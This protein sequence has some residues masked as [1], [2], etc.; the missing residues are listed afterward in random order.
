MVAIK[1]NK[2]G[3]ISLIYF[4]VIVSILFLGSCGG[5]GNAGDGLVNDDNGSARQYTVGGTVS[6]LSGTVVLQNNGGN[7]LTVS[8]N[9][10]FTFLKTVE[11][12]SSYSV[13]VL[14]QPVEQTCSVS[15]GTGTLSGA[16]IS[17]VVVTCSATAYYVGGTLSGLSGTVVLQNNGG[18]N[19]IITA[20]GPFTFPLA[21]ADGSPFA[22]TVLTQPAGQACSVANGTGSLAH[23]DVTNVAVICSTITRT[24][25]IAKGGTGTGTLSSAPAGIDCGPVCSASY[26]LGTR[27]TL[28]AVPSS[29]TIFEGFSGGCTGITSSCTLTLTGDTAVSAILNSASLSKAGNQIGLDGGSAVVV[30]QK[31]ANPPTSTLD[32]TTF[33][34]EAWVFPLADQDMLIVADSAYYLMVKAPTATQPLG[35]EFAVLTS[36]GFPAFKFFA[37]SIRPFKLAQWNHVVGMVDNINKYLWLGIN[38]ELTGPLSIAGNVDTSY[39]QTFSVGNAYPSSLGNYPFIGRIDEIRLSSAIR[40]NVDFTP[41]S[42]LD[43]DGSTAGLW[44]FDETA[45]AASFI[46][47]SG[48]SNMLIGLNGAAAIAG[49]RDV[50]AGGNSLFYSLIRFDQSSIILPTAGPIAIG[51]FNNDGSNDMAIAG[52]YSAASSS[53]GILLGRGGGIFGPATLFSTGENGAH[54]SIAMADFNKDG[55]VDLAVTN[56]SKND[57]SILLNTGAGS[58]GTPAT[59]AT[60]TNPG[61]IAV[62]DFNGNG[63]AD[64]AVANYGSNSVSVYLGTGTGS[65]GSSTSYSVSANPNSVAVGDFNQDGILDLAVANSGGNTVSILLGTGTGSFGPATNFAVGNGPSSSPRSIAL[66]D[67]NKDGNLDIATANFG[68]NNVTVLLG[69]GTGSFGTAANY[70]VPFGGPGN[71]AIGDLNGDGALDIEVAS[72]GG[73]AVYVVLLG[74]GSGSFNAAIPYNTGDNPLS[75]AIGDLTGDG[76]PDMAMGVSFSKIHIYVAR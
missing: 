22:V 76:K 72:I 27:V 30:H 34:I 1:P 64:L 55:H 58:F 68:S 47:S 7:D 43:P 49:T 37:G 61:S 65:F 3:A 15:S 71:L 31:T 10:Q 57:I 24:L 74:N 2:H 73:N 54:S 70:A 4:A 13:T 44:H 12:G 36:T 62:G 50:Q 69:S 52:V 38:G 39:S 56:W 5:G 67:F 28:T 42:L 59:F 35:V 45:S 40:Y 6:G 21:L 26:P 23:A 17:V 60:G 51:D 18:N 14:T 8:A 32:L 53:L 46:D 11:D 9:G 19:L 29:G 66:G 75:V 20:N 41:S 16:N 33:T 25:A 63:N 48:N